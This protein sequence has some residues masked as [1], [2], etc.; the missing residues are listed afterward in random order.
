MTFPTPL[1]GTQTPAYPAG[2]T[3]M[4]IAQELADVAVAASDEG[5]R[6]GMAV[7]EAALEAAAEASRRAEQAAELAVQ[8]AAEANAR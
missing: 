7:S 8:R 6:A 2:K 3:P 1:S 4:E 5:V